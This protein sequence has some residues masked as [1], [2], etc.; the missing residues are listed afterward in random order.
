MNADKTAKGVGDCI[1]VGASG[2]G[3]HALHLRKRRSRLA[4]DIDKT[5][6][7]FLLRII[8]QSTVLL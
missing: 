5:P 8:Y 6:D 7:N 1:S 4:D 3:G 2:N